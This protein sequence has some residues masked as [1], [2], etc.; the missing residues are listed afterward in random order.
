MLIFENEN[1]EIWN[2]I[3]LLKADTEHF[4][5]WI[6]ETSRLDH[7]QYHL[8]KVKQYLYG[9]VIDVGAYIG[10]MTI[11]YA[12]YSPRVVAIEPLFDAYQCLKWNM[13]EQDNVDCI[14]AAAGSKKGKCSLQTDSNNIGMTY[15]KKGKDVDVIT[16]DSLGY[17]EVSYMK[18]DVEGKE[19][20]VL[21][22]AR[23]TI[24]RWKPI[25]DIEV[26]NATLEREGISDVILTDYIFDMGYVVIDRV[27]SAPQVDI[28]CKHKSRI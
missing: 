8:Q 21:K 3:A 13:A 12:Q 27:G 28:I 15:V 25:L 1:I 4:S 6:K 22:G 17:E 18:I 20:E 5:K 9:T 2:N 11:F 7:N 14:N 24:D 23:Q 19:L 16:I 26:N 10:D